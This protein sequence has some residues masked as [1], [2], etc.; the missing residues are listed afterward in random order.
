M[1]TRYHTLYQ[2][3]VVIID[4]DVP[5][6]GYAYFVLYLYLI[7]VTPILAYVPGFDSSYI[8]IYI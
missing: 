8:Y 2:G 1:R 7:R 5:D 6:S 4:C 3:T